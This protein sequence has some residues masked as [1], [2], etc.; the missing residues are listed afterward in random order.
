MLG[1]EIGEEAAD[2]AVGDLLVP[3]QQLGLDFG[4][5][6]PAVAQLT[7]AAP[8]S[9]MT[10]T[11]SGDSSA[12]CPRAASNLIRTCGASRGRAESSMRAIGLVDGSRACSTARRT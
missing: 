6:P 1:D 8:V 4:D 9:L 10:Q 5:G 2:V 12:C 3:T 11:V 7:M